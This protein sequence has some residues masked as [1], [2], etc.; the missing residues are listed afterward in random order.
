MQRAVLVPALSAI[1]SGVIVA[2]T[3]GSSFASACA[4]ARGKYAVDCV[5][6]DGRVE[7]REFQL[8]G[9][10]SKQNTATR[11]KPRRSLYQNVC[12]PMWFFT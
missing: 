1:G 11:D 2:Q 6:A 3:R 10:W 7:T 9:A 12:V 4:A 8:E 5:S